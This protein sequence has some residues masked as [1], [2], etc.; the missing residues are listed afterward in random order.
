MKFYSFLLC[1]IFFFGINCGAQKET[2]MK[3]NY[4]DQNN[5]RY[6]IT[7]TSFTYIPI[8]EKE[9]SSG[10]Y[11]GG[12]PVSKSI[13]KAEF[14]TLQQLAEELIATASKDVKREMMTSVLSI[15]KNGSIERVTLRKSAKRNEFEALLKS[16][17]STSE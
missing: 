14:I 4:T 6:L 9:S 16:L 15:P 5:N 8:T 12:N 7:E 17:K 2:P 1:F 3:V 13:T 10:T 11:H